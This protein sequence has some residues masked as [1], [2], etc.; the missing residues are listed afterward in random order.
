MHSVI[1]KQL[2]V[3]MLVILVT[4]SGAGFSSAVKASC[5]VDA[6]V[7]ATVSTDSHCHSPS[8]LAQAAEH[9]D[10]SCSPYAPA[11]A[12]AI[13]GA[14]LTSSPQW[15]MK[16]PYPQSHPERLEKPPRLSLHF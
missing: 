1:A 16:V 8:L 4:L 6:P 14:I 9:A 10:A 12:N 11:A 7:S 3:M 2:T 13:S 5:L 15:L